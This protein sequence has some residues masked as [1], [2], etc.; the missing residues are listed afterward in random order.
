MGHQKEATEI[1]RRFSWLRRA[2][3]QALPHPRAAWSPPRPQEEGG[4]P[5]LITAVFLGSRTG[6]GTQEALGAC[7]V[8]GTGT[9]PTLGRGRPR[10]REVKQRV[11]GRAARRKLSRDDLSVPS[12]PTLS[13]PR[14]GSPLWVLV[15]G[16]GGVGLVLGGVAKGSLGR[17][18]AA[19]PGHWHQMVR[20][21][22]PV[23]PLTSRATLSKCPKL[24]VHDCREGRVTVPGPEYT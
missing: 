8:E 5:D 11:R 2:V 3:R 4:P 15:S 9:G 10:P 22:I 16:G 12:V 18:W 24:S 14:Q 6:P 19:L 20:V 21:Q 7:C 1:A 13:A 23:M 17:S